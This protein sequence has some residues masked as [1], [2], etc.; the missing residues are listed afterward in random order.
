MTFIILFAIIPIIVLSAT[1][2]GKGVEP[3]N[4]ESN[5]VFRSKLSEWFI[6]TSKGTY[7]RDL[8]R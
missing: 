7:P 4:N 8:G 2:L 5:I 3:R 6:S 1:V